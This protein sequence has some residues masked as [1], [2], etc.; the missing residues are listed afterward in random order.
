[1]SAD[2]NS[3]E[4]IERFNFSAVPAAVKLKCSRPRIFYHNRPH[5]SVH[6]HK[7]NSIMPALMKSAA[8]FI[9]I[10]AVSIKPLNMQIVSAV[11]SL[12]FSVDHFV[13][14][15]ISGEF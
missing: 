11:R 10:H 15:K 3:D 2:I 7:L 9:F 8:T 4:Q 1:M 14:H 13:I 5:T 6:R 12:E